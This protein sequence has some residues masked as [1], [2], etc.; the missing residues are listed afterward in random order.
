MMYSDQ[1][2]GPVSV[3]FYGDESAAV[4]KV[5]IT[6]RPISSD[7]D[8]FLQ[9]KLTFKCFTVTAISLVIEHMLKALGNRETN[10]PSLKISA[11][12]FF[13]P[14]R[15]VCVNALYKF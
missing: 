2:I 8:M 10:S 5:N 4:G 7:R 15:F 6:S 12:F 1:V 13:G 11:H 9:L 3:L 14:W